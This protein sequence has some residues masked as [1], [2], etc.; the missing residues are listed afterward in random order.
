M[1]EVCNTGLLWKI[2]TVLQYNFFTEIYGAELNHLLENKSDYGIMSMVVSAE[3][4][5]IEYNKGTTRIV[6]YRKV[7]EKKKEG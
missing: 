1:T 4:I 5:S 2:S 6:E 3:K 7:S